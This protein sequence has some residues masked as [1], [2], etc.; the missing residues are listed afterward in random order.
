MEAALI[1]LFRYHEKLPYTIF[2]KTITASVKY[3]KYKYKPITRNEVDK[4]GQILLQLGIDLIREFNDIDLEQF[5]TIITV[6]PNELIK[7]LE[8]HP[9]CE[10]IYSEPL[11]LFKNGHFNEAVRKATERFEVEI[12]DRTGSTDIGKGLM[13]KTFKLNNPDIQLNN[14]STENEKGIQEGF[15]FLTMGMMRAMRNI[16]SHG[17]EDQRPAEEAYEMLL[18]INWLF[19]QLP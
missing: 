8:S 15:Q 5:N 1:K 19:K 18:F 4:L 16:F 13:S 9:L 12:Q 10:Q 2:R 14:L 3:R 11:E 6:P 7:R 17:D